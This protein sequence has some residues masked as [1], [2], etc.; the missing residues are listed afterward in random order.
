M[1][2]AALTTVCADVADAWDAAAPP[3]GGP[4]VDVVG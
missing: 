1:G 2:S 4:G 3:V